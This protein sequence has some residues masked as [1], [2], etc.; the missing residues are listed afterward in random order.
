[1]AKGKSKK[2]SNR[3]I[4]KPKAPKRTDVTA[5]VSIQTS[6]VLASTHKRKG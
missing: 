3:E 6:S 5:P 1:M 2:R 4:R